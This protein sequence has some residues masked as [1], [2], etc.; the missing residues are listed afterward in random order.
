MPI[1]LSKHFS[2]FRKLLQEADIPLLVFLLLFTN[3]SVITLKL[4]GLLFIYLLRFN[5]RF[6]LRK[7][8][9]P[10][11]YVLII[12][13]SCINLLVHIPDHSNKYL[14]AFGVAN[15]FWFMCM[16]GYHQVKLSLERYGPQT[17]HR[18]LQLYCLIN[19]VACV[20]Q[21]LHIMYVT[22]S[23]NPYNTNL[24]FPYGISTGDNVY[25]VLLQN[26]Y[27]NIMIS[28][29]LAIYF[30]FRNNRLF[31]MLNV[32]CMLLVFG[33]M[34]T[35][36]FVVVV[37]MIFI[38]SL[39]R[40]LIIKKDA[41]NANKLL[42]WI[43]Q[44]TLPVRKSFFVLAIFLFVIII[45][46]IVSPANLR[47]TVENLSYKFANG[48][49]AT[50][51]SLPDNTPLKKPNAIHHLVYEQDTEA[52]RNRVLLTREYL[53]HFQGKKLSFWETELFLTSSTSNFL[54]GAGPVRFSSLIAQ[55]M[56][57]M[58][59]SR[60]FRTILPNYT[61]DEYYDNHGMLILVRIRDDDP[62]YRA[63]INWPDSF[64]NQLLGEY[65]ALGTLLFLIFYAGYFIR[66][67]G[68][69][70]YSLWL[71]V[72]MVPFAWLSY[73]FEPLCVMV[74]FEMLMETDMLTRKQETIT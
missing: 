23:L 19:L 4:A 73:L 33:N 43:E 65:G 24:P 44:I 35:L 45:Y 15:A 52:T 31:C 54:L 56:G 28:S 8:R 34:G 11:F 47:Y 62:Q 5:V 7:N 16:L 1:S 46:A 40:K 60:L 69:W 39:L 26:S 38:A 37:A 3:Q 55:R 25:G 18:T 6:G 59:S 9:M 12:L 64:Y 57:G 10:L 50:H 30:L 49:A 68:K 48:A 32:F 71:C 70:S 27:Y 21:V 17:M 14:I 61:N 2:S 22:H 29:L 42:R 51:L 41:R 72:A 67:A 53:R 13:L 20:W 63:S 36:I 66:R 74:F 58:D